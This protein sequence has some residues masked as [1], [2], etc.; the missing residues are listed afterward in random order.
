MSTNFISES[1]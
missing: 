1:F